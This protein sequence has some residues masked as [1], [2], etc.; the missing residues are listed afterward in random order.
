MAVRFDTLLA[1]PSARCGDIRVETANPDQLNELE[2]DWLDLLGRAA[3]SNVFMNPALL[4]VAALSYPNRKCVALLA[5]QQ[6][7]HARRLVGVWGLTVRRSAHAIFP[8]QVLA[9]PAM[10]HGYLVTPVIDRSLFDAVLATMLDYIASDPALPNIVSLEI[11][12]ADREISD[13]FD[14]V[15]AARGSA[16]CVLRQ[17]VRPSLLAVEKRSDYLE[18]T[19]SSSTRKKLRQHRRKL[20]AQGALEYR[21]ARD[22]ETV[23]A[24]FEDFLNIEAA[25]WKGRSG[26]ALLKHA[27]DA[28]FA[29]AMAAVLADR[30]DITMHGLYLDGRAISSQVV[31]HAG[32]AAF[33]WKTA[34]E[35]SLG[36]CSP[37]MLLFENYT[38]SFLADERVA[39][40]DS[41]AVDDSGFMAAW[42]GR[43]PIAAIWIDARRG[44]SASFAALAGLQRKFVEFRFALK[45]LYHDGRRRI[46]HCR[47]ALGR[48]TAR[49]IP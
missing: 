13:G 4:R 11:L 22:P 23:R 32:A 27:G 45:P 2:R 18:H 15:L 5:W 1:E 38:A 12:G 43:Q 46:A 7:P 28:M 48:V 47:R 17:W 41:C 37:G 8:F 10:P 16:A 14:R 34:Y 9:A 26:T 30:G 35:E 42:P 36:D 39:S 33:T 49:L 20:A 29:R 3:V 40:V 24:A 25:G 44:R 6:T 19:L 21:I 31:L